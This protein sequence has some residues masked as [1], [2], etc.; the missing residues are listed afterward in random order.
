MNRSRC[1][2]LFCFFYHGVIFS[3]DT[4]KDKGEIKVNKAYI[5]SY[6]LDAR[7][8]IVAPINL[9]TKQC[10][11]IS[12]FAGATAALMSWGDKPIKEFA[13]NHRSNFGDGFFL[14]G[15]EHWGDGMYSMP[16]M[17]SFYI[18]GKIRHD[19]RAVKTA[20]VGVKTFVITALMVSIPKEL[21]HRQRPHNTDDP[22]LFH[23]P[24][25]GLFKDQNRSFPS[26]HSM[27][28]FAMATVIASEYKEYKIV[29]V[30]AYSLASLT[31]LSR[32]Y[33]EKHWS[34][35]I[36][37]GSAFGYVM[38]RIIHQKNNWNISPFYS[39]TVSGLSVKIPIE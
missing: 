15:A 37:V 29:P 8:I 36:L 30:V 14:F 35:D 6:F 17:A 19:D 5:K 10:L 38:A 3:Q 28:A 33:F 16:L 26:G 18:V 32:V 9:R 25:S 1:I 22:L 24:F 20:M 4:I 13:N 21:F 12:A 31:A 23:G 7:D 39:N 34:S 11:K 2:L 27:S